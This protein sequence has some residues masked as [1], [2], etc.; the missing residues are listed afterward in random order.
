[1]EVVH[2]MMVTTRRFFVIPTTGSEE[3]GD[4]LDFA[5]PSELFPPVSLVLRPNFS[6]SE[7]TSLPIF[8]VLVRFGASVRVQY[9]FLEP[10]TARAVNTHTQKA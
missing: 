2:R 6:A 9:K 4:F 8:G 10:V 1:V 7:P 5:I 3:P